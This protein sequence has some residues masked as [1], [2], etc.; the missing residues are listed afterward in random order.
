MLEVPDYSIIFFP[1]TE[2]RCATCQAGA[3]HSFTS[4]PIIPNTPQSLN[5][6][7]QT[8]NPNARVTVVNHT[9]HCIPP[10]SAHVELITGEVQA[11]GVR[12]TWG[13]CSRTGRSPRACVTA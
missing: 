8:L 10:K 13:T 12:A 2:I 3:G 6:K 5:P 4:H 1:R 9:T 11:L 7:P